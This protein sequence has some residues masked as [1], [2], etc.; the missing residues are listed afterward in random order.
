MWV[1][2]SAFVPCSAARWL[3]FDAC[4]HRAAAACE[5]VHLLD[6]RRYLA[7]H[8]LGRIAMGAVAARNDQAPHRAS[9][10]RLDPIE[11]VESAVGI[12]GPLDQEHR[13]GDSLGI[14]L[15]RPAPER[16]VEPDVAPVP[17][18][19]VRIVVVTRQSLAQVGRLE[20]LAGL[21]NRGE[22]HVLDDDVRS[23]QDEPADRVRPGVDQRDRGAVAVPDEDR[24]LGVEP[25]EDLRENVERLLVEERRRARLR[26]RIRPAVPEAARTR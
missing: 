25:A 20:A 16:R 10:A 3:R 1:P 22:R 23:E 12:V 5:L 19:D 4:R 8:R 26:R 2:Y 6:E 18:G 24:L 17:E 15:E 14:R 9:N 21:A 7:E 13:A 11:L